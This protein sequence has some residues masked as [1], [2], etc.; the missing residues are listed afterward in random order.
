MECLVLEGGRDRRGTTIV[1]REGLRGAR[2]RFGCGCISIWDVQVQDGE[3][4]GEL[5]L[6]CHNR[7]RKDGTGPC[8][9][10]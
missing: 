8:G 1:R 5:T 6:I 4:H 2:L 3:D 10:R 7:S 9:R